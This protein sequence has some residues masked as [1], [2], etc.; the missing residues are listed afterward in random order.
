MPYY[1]YVIELDPEVAA[2]S[3]FCER[4]PEMEPGGPC[5]Y[6]GQS[7]HEP[8]CRYRQHKECHGPV[9]KFSCICEKPKGDFSKN[10]SNR[11]ARKYGRWL[12]RDLF[13]KRNPLRTRR[14]AEAMEARLAAEL[15]A[16]GCG[17][18]WG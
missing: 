2:I 7:V 13:E 16:R 12:K 3:R 9:I 1:V 17:V 5:Y 4:N 6:V 18:W 8:D 15:Q 14:E 10:L 11:Y